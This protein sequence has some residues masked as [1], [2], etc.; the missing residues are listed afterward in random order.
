MSIKSQLKHAAYN[1]VDAVFARLDETDI[2]VRG[3]RVPFVPDVPDGARFTELDPP[4]NAVI[5][6]PAV[7]E[8]GERDQFS[9]LWQR[10][11]RGYPVHACGILELPSARFHL[12]S[13]TVSAAGK[14]PAET[15]ELLDF[16]FRHQYLDALRTLWTPARRIEDGYLLTL[17]QSSNYYHWVCEVLPLAFA[18][19]RDTRWGEMPVYVAADLPPFVFEYLR[20]LGLDRFCHPLPRGVYS[21]DSLRVPTFPSLAESPSPRHVSFL[22]EACLKAVGPSREPRRRLVVSRADAVGRRVLNEDQLL[23]AI[24]DLGFERVTL[25][26]MSVVE[27][28]RL[29]ASAEMLIAPQGAGNSNVLFAPADCAFAELLAPANNTWSFMVLASTV[30]QVYGYVGGTQVGDNLV[31][32]VT[33]VR[34]VVE[35][36]LELRSTASN[37]VR[38]STRGATG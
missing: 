8:D 34:R 22:R 15:V 23:Q 16:P 13:G 2:N 6:G 38:P 5:R 24:D 1:V 12:P 28:I 14:F 27:Q 3:R 31:V 10:V 21:A 4:Y 32:D 30:G 9:R 36:L 7:W 29:F 25:A 33:Q 19:M 26:G 35:R 20:L 18:L 17:Q 37:P 11:A